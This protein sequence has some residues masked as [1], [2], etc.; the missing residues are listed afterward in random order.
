MR[1]NDDF[2]EL[3]HDYH[4]CIENLRLWRN[5]RVEGAQRWVDEYCMLKSELETEIQQFLS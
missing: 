2:R 3:C 4:A 5:S 1:E